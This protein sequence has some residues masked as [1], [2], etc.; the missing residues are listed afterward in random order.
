LVGQFVNQFLLTLLLL[1]QTLELA[2]LEVADQ[3]LLLLGFGHRIELAEFVLLEHSKCLEVRHPLL[4]NLLV[5]PFRRHCH[6][7]PIR[8]SFAQLHTAIELHLRTLVAT[9]GQFGLE[10][11]EFLLLNV[12]ELGFLSFLQESEDVDSLDGIEILDVRLGDLTSLASAHQEG[13]FLVA[14][15]QQLVYSPPVVDW[16]PNSHCLVSLD[17][18]SLL[19]GSKHLLS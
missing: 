9:R 10:F 11:G 8:T 3:D 14:L 18:G 7:H 2:L 13:V 19:G 1:Q 5:T 12:D 17:H 6:P 4:P 16:S 15:A